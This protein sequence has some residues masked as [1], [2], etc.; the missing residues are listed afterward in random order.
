M[1]NELRNHKKSDSFKWWLTL[2]AFILMG[3]TLLG[4]VTG[5]IVPM[6]KSDENVPT[7]EQ[8]E[9]ANVAN[10]FATEFISTQNVRLMAATPMALSANSAYVEQTLTANVLP[11]TATNK[12]VD[13]SVSWADG[14]SG[15]VTDYVT[16]TP[17][18]DGS[19]T[20]SVKCYKAFTGN[21]V[22]TVT[23]R[24]SGYTAECIVTFVGVPTSLTTTGNF[25]ESADGYYYFGVGD[26][27]TYSVDLNNIFG[28]VGV[29]YQDVNMTLGAYGSVVL[30]TYEYY[31]STGN[32]TWYDSSLTTVTLESLKDK[33]IS[34][35]Y[36]NGVLTITT[37]KT[38]E[39]YYESM[40]RIDGGRTRNYTNK[41]KEYATD[42]AY[43]YIRLDQP[44]SGLSKLMKIKFDATVVA[45]VESSSTQIYF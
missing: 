39:S 4:L 12:K 13:W 11:T 42:D 31:T 25:S 23:T 38:I 45:G 1:E 43:F 18:S 28:T 14:Q 10:D 41:F 22:I 5:F 36:A 32:S 8:T 19:T 15:T 7:T 30:G 17:S 2:I 35:S 34:A 6:E 3:A 21:V 33:F 44:D 37:V 24:E 16:V 26:A 9:T 40:S 29:D 20:A 27:Y